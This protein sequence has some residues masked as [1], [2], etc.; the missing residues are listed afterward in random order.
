MK[1]GAFLFSWGSLACLMESGGACLHPQH[2]KSPAWDPGRKAVTQTFI[3]AWEKAS[4]VLGLPPP[5]CS[6][7]QERLR[8]EE[9][10]PCQVSSM[11]LRQQS[12]VWVSLVMPRVAP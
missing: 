11:S 4:P 8:Q 12:R 5:L 1:E 9:K 6:G 10:R 7:P 2:G 3:S